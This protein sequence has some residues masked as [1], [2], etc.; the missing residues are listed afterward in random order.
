MLRISSQHTLTYRVVI[1]SLCLVTAALA[2]HV[3]FMETMVLVSKF[4]ISM[5]LVIVTLLLCMLSFELCDVFLENDRLIVK[6]INELGYISIAQIRAIKERNFLGF[7]ITHL[8]FKEKTPFG[9][10]TLF[11]PDRTKLENEDMVGVDVLKNRLNKKN[12]PGQNDQADKA[13]DELRHS[14]F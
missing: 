7:Q 4:L 2:S 11:I 5:L 14:K 3:L 8:S 1:F 12:Q 10:S 9:I 6:G 13:P